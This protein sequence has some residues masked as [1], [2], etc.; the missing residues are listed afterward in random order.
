MTTEEIFELPKGEKKIDKGKNHKDNKNL[1]LSDDQCIVC[2]GNLPKISDQH[3]LQ[4][5]H[6]RCM[7]I[8]TRAIL[9]GKIPKEIEERMK[10]SLSKL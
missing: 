9:C 4:R 10:A 3:V 8:M 6:G 1:H 7:Q 5:D 2:Q